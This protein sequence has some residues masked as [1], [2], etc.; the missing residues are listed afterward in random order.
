ME[1]PR[2]EYAC[3]IW[4][5]RWMIWT[6]VTCIEPWQYMHCEFC[7]D[8]DRRSGTAKTFQEAIDDI[9]DYMEE[10]GQWH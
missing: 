8:T 3:P 9:R 7:G 4:Y 2:I 10:Y 5:G 1:V 6:D